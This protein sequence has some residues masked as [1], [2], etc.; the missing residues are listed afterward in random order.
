M[1]PGHACMNGKALTGI[2]EKLKLGD[3]ARGLGRFGEAEKRF[4]ES[5][6]DRTGERGHLARMGRT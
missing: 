4:P 6:R 2:F 5:R 3:A 1:T